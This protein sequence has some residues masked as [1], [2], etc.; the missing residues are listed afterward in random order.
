MHKRWAFISV[1]CLIAFLGGIYLLACAQS[2]FAGEIK[3]NSLAVTAWVH[4]LQKT[5]PQSAL[6]S[7]QSISW[8]LNHELMAE[9]FEGT[10]EQIGD[11]FSLNS[12]PTVWDDGVDHI[13]LIHR[14]ADKAN[15]IVACTLEYSLCNWECARAAIRAKAE[16]QNGYAVA[17]ALSI[18]ELWKKLPD[19][20][21]SC[22]FLVPLGQKTVRVTLPTLIE[23]WISDP[24]HAFVKPPK[25]A[26]LL[27]GLTL[28]VS[29]PQYEKRGSTTVIGVSSDE[30]LATSSAMIP[31]TSQ[32][33][34]SSLED[35]FSQFSMA[36]P[37]NP[38]QF[39]EQD[40]DKKSLELISALANSLIMILRHPEVGDNFD[41]IKL[42]V[43][44]IHKHRYLAHNLRSI[45]SHILGF[46]PFALPGKHREQMELLRTI[47]KYLRSGA[48]IDSPEELVFQAF[49]K[50][51]E[52]AD[53]N[54]LVR[55]F[56]MKGLLTPDT[57][58]KVNTPDQ[59]LSDVYYSEKIQQVTTH[60]KQ[61][62]R[63]QT[64]D[65]H[66]RSV[67]GKEAEPLMD[68]NSRHMKVRMIQSL[69]NPSPPTHVPSAIAITMP[70]HHRTRILVSE[71]IQMLLDNGFSSPDLSRDLYHQFTSVDWT[72]RSQIIMSR[73]QFNIAW[74]IA[75]EE[76]RDEGSTVQKIIQGAFK[77]DR[78]AP[79]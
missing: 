10:R 46:Y 37:V 50:K 44:A 53:H 43:D 72:N 48:I 45:E 7:L 9:G 4:H 52:M 79:L 67:L 74:Q 28:P 75:Q 32:W 78:K 25:A 35:A 21:K 60:R 77:V 19:A 33:N 17:I 59:T 5:R 12:P 64:R 20:V 57:I 70:A 63:P 3:P 66:L 62:S 69:T 29:L 71:I 55:K 65:S 38:D 68:R 40:K 54:S 14:C 58:A 42:L 73:D 18:I 61:L 2:I 13:D 11:V 6:P 26:G 34:I 23:V 27:D 15:S 1:Q 22:P 41:L 51:L 16:T 47:L 49:Q 76:L 39:K 31:D 30:A 56:I 24:S 8:K 36:E